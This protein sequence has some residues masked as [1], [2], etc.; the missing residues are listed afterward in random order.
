VSEKQ[1]ERELVKEERVEG[2]E[3]ER[4]NEREREKVGEGQ[5]GRGWVEAE[6]ETKECVRERAS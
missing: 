1:R 2:S 6:G 4:G 5:T 3:G